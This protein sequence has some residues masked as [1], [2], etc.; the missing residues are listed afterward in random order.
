MRHHCT[1]QNPRNLS[2]DGLSRQV[3]NIEWSKWKTNAPKKMQPEERESERYYTFPLNSQT[4]N[5][6][7]IMQS[8]TEDDPGLFSGF[9]KKILPDFLPGYHGPPMDTMLKR[10][11]LMLV[12][13]QKIWETM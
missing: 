1:P 10:E 7:L 9:P 13:L 12:A 4:M 3:G 6:N 8:V 11:D 5:T 2:Y